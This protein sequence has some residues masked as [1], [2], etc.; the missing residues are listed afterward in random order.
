MLSIVGFVG[1]LTSAY[2]R[3]PLLICISTGAVWACLGYAVAILLGVFHRIV[4]GIGF[5]IFAL[6]DAVSLHS[7]G[8]T[9]LVPALLLLMFTAL[10][11]WAWWTGFRRAALLTRAMLDNR[12]P[13]AVT[14]FMGAGA[15]LA[16]YGISDAADILGW[17]PPCTG[18]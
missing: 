17:S 16:I 8:P 1:M 13:L 6:L 4:L 18:N 2:L 11:L 7:Q 3:L 9:A 10:G 5:A 12:S 14:A 15:A